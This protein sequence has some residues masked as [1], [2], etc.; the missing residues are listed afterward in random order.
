MA[1]DSGEMPGPDNDKIRKRRNL[2]IAAVLGGLVLLVFFMT[3]HR[4][5]QIY[6]S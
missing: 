6:G 1:E 4:I 5:G 3:M 2:A